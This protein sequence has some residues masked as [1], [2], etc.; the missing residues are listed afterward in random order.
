MTTQLFA[1][2]SSVA[3]VS[4]GVWIILVGSYALHYLPK[5]FYDNLMQSYI[6]LPAVLQGLLL[7]GLGAGLMQVVSQDVVPYIYFQFDSY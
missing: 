2:T 4:V 3:Q 5:R 6:R 1:G 7:A